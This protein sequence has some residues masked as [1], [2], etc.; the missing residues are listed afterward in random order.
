MIENAMASG[1]KARATTVPASKSRRGLASHCWRAEAMMDIQDFSGRAAYG[2]SVSRR[3]GGRDSHPAAQGRR[4]QGERRHACRYGALNAR[5][6]L[7][8]QE[9]WIHRDGRE[10]VSNQCEGD[11]ACGGQRDDNPWW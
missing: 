4:V 10:R 6:V 3:M 9:S 1:I 2:G 11:P 8:M 7:F 5:S